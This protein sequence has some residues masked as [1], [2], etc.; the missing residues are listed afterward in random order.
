MKNEMTSRERMLAAM[1]RHPVDHIPLGQ[2]FH[3]T[4]LGTPPNRQWSNQFERS[5]IMK[6]LGIDPVIDIWMPAP[7]PPPDVRVRRWSEPDSDG[8][9]SLLCAEYETPAGNLVQKVRKT[10]D[11]YDSTHHRFLPTWD[12]DAFRPKDGYHELEMMDD[13]FTRRYKV[14][15]IRG[16]ED[17]DKLPY[18]LKAPQGAARDAWLRNAL[19]A[20]RIAKEMDLLTQARR[21]SVGDWFMWVCLIEDFCIAMVED[22]AYVSRFLDICQD[23]SLEILNMVAEVAPDLVQCRGWYDTPD[24]W[25]AGRFRD[26]LM[27]R[28]AHLASKAHD[29]GTLFCYLLP[30]GYTLYR[31][32]LRQIDVDVFFGLEPLASRKTE[33]LALVKDSLGERSALWGGVNAH[34]T[35]GTGTPEEI[36]RAVLTAIETL[37]PRGFILNA[38][39]YIS[40]DD[41]RWDKFM[42]LLGAWRK[43]GGI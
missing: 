41:V 42:A 9:Y 8:P 29:G 26:V 21:L 37:G 25:G 38:S 35:V 3:S 5:R 24:Y 11:W 43:Y 10:P 28:I 40:D 22:P 16:P 4:V 27:P 36:D 39:I 15:L 2:V 6:D 17:L 1:K 20:K 34:V 13:W 33:N 31:D 7:E 12:G 23:Y 14:P 30:E 32:Y 18:L 19:E